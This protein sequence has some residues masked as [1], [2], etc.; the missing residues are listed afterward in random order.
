MPSTPVYTFEINGTPVYPNDGLTIDLIV[1]GLDTAR[2]EIYSEDGSFIPLVDDEVVIEEDGDVIFAGLIVTAKTKGIGGIGSDAVTTSI[3]MSDYSTYASFR[4][5]DVTIPAGT[6]LKDAV[7]TY[8][9]P[10]LSPYGVTLHGS[11]V[12]G[13]A[14]EQIV[15]TDKKVGEVFNHL[16]TVAQMVWKI[17]TT[18]VLRFYAGGTV[19]APWNITA[20]DLHVDGDVEVTPSMDKFANKVTVRAGQSGGIPNFLDGPFTGDGVTDTFTLTHK[21]GGPLQE[22][23]TDSAVG[24]CVVYVDGQQE[25]LGGLTSPMMWLYDPVALTIQRNPAYG[26]PASGAVITVPY[27]AIMQSFLVSADDLADQGTRGIREIRLIAPDVFTKAAA[28]QLADGTLAKA[29][30]IASTIKYSTTF[31]GLFPGMTQNVV[32]PNRGLSA[33]FLVT[34]IKLRQDGLVLK[35]EVTAITGNDVPE[36]WRDTV[37]RWDD[38]GAGGGSALR[39]LSGFSSSGPGPIYVATL[40]LTDA[41]IKA[42]ADNPISGVAAPGVGKRLKLIAATIHLGTTDGAYTN[43]DAG[44]GIDIICGGKRMSSGLYGTEYQNLFD[45]AHHKVIDI[46]APAMD[47]VSSILMGEDVASAA[48]ASDVGNA[49][50][51]LN[52]DN[53]GSGAFTGGNG[54]NGAVIYFYYAIE[55]VGAIWPNLSSVTPT[56]S[57]S[58]NLWSDDFESGAALSVDYTDISDMVK[59]AGVGN[60]GTQGIEGSGTNAEKY[61]AEISKTFTPNSRNGCISMDIKPNAAIDQSGHYYIEVH[62]PGGPNDVMAFGLYSGGSYAGTD[63][64]DISIYKSFSSSIVD[65]DEALTD[66]VYKTVRVEFEMSSITAGARNADGWVKLYVDDVL[67]ADLTGQVIGAYH[68]TNNPNNYWGGVRFAP[69]GAGDNILVRN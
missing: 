51:M 61:Y 17:D 48:A 27:D 53:N 26:P 5:A 13:P 33:D 18:K 29:L 56:S 15:V 4:Y 37:R 40:V 7:Q 59:S 62:A 47:V 66:G 38:L 19:P 55:N 3:S 46:P 2:A 21:I 6:T 12:T 31:P 24:N 23:G 30:F 65:V 44:G 39:S 16:A 50:L 25:S 60:G 52:I 67:L 41:Q 57:C 14:L 35:R 42:G 63:F 45:T 34:E 58:S 36:T 10:Y 11:Q 1:S 28:Q 9:L 69:Q 54:N 20:N 43:V 68:V 64:G 49:P 8:L 22:V 32:L